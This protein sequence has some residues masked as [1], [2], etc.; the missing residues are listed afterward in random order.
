L[1]IFLATI[2]L[3]HGSV[4]EWIST[5]ANGD[6][7][8]AIVSEVIVSLALSYPIPAFHH[9]RL[10]GKAA[11]VMHCVHRRRDFEI[12]GFGTGSPQCEGDRWIRT[13]YCKRFPSPDGKRWFDLRKQSDGKVYFQEFSEGTPIYGTDSCAS[14]GFKSSV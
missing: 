13:R 7:A 10:K 8:S 11:R 14:P 3:R 5:L 2:K 4:I 9:I 6:G 12:T 1:I